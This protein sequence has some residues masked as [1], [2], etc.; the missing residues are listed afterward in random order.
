MAGRL[1]A[2]VG[3]FLLMCAG[4]VGD[5]D[6]DRGKLIGKWK[7]VSSGEGGEEWV[8][9]TVGDS[10]R[11]SHSLKQKADQVE[12]NIMGKDCEVKLAGH[13]A[14][15][16]FWFNGSMLVEMETRGTEVIK[17]RFKI[18]DNDTLKLE[19][20]QIVP[21]GKTETAEFKRADARH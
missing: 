13:K 6:A 18:A 3:L 9:E 1:A 4:A 17:R 15:V 11:L 10:L 21:P 19:T 8:L 14:K 20:V 16:S 5:D 2:L 7:P 12:C